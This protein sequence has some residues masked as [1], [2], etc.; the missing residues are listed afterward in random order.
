MRNWLRHLKERI[1]IPSGRAIVHLVVVQIVVQLMWN[2]LSKM[3]ETVLLREVGF[4][5]LFIVGLI[6]VA[7]YLP[8]LSPIL[9]GPSRKVEEVKPGTPDDVHGPTDSVENSVVTQEYIAER[10]S[11][12]QQLRAT[13]DQLVKNVHF[14][15][16]ESVAHYFTKFCEESDVRDIVQPDNMATTSMR[17]IIERF[18]SFTFQCLEHQERGRKLTASIITDDDI[19]NECYRIN[20]AVSEYRHVVDEWMK[21]MEALAEKGMPRFWEK[22]PWS[23]NIHRKL[24][25]DYDE[26][27]RLVKDL[28]NAT[29]RAFQNLLPNDDQLTKFPRVPLVG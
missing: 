29:P 23:V 1:G 26:L 18:H 22:P 6:V 24:A 3:F 13:E 15:S 2:W 12:I 9:G 7:W 20:Q 11:F 27:M 25:D 19:R 14:N 4:L 21:F 5:V 10:L 16:P 17:L 8:K 28:R